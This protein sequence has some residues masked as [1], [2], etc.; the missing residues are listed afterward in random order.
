MALALWHGGQSIAEKPEA[1]LARLNIFEMDQEDEIPRTVEVLDPD[2]P[3]PIKDILVTVEETKTGSLMFGLGVNSDAGLTSS[4][5]LN[6]RTFEIVCSPIT[7]P[8]HQCSE[9]GPMPGAVFDWYSYLPAP[10]AR[11]RV[12]QRTRIDFEKL[13]KGFGIWGST[14]EDWEITSWLGLSAPTLPP[15]L[16]FLTFKLSAVQACRQWVTWGSDV[17][18]LADYRNPQLQQLTHPDERVRYH[19]AI[20][21]GQTGADYAI[22]LLHATMAGDP[23][24]SVRE[25]AA[26]SLA[27]L[28]DLGDIPALRR[29]AREDSD[30]D[31]QRIAAFAAEVIEGRCGYTIADLPSVKKPATVDMQFFGF[32]N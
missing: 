16:P 25:A 13:P 22:D 8:L 29:A 20:Q 18:Y 23:S 32:F 6:E 26:R 3:N 5:V 19:A 12:Y 27:K 11:E 21:F 31:V 15:S 17:D 1:R 9:S 2:G 10:P 4:I 30:E 24:P 14:D 28:G 7:V